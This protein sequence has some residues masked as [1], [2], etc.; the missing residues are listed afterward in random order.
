LMFHF[1]T[2]SSRVFP[3]ALHP[4]RGRPITHMIDDYCGPAEV[5]A[6]RPLGARGGTNRARRQPE[7]IDEANE[8]AGLGAAHKRSLRASPTRDHLAAMTMQGE[9]C[10]R[11]AISRRPRSGPARSARRPGRARHVP[12]PRCS[13]SPRR[14]TTRAARRH[15]GRR[16]RDLHRPLGSDHRAAS[17]AELEG[18]H[19]CRSQPLAG[20][21]PPARR[22]GSANDPATSVTDR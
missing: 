4:H 21:A 2:T 15:H 1:Q 9:D 5:A 7:R 14:P 19:R 10:R 12:E 8:R 17:A 18:G 3:G 13:S 20:L 22:S 16:G 6:T 11:P